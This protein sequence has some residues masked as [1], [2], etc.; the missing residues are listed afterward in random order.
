MKIRNLDDWLAVESALEE[1][2]YLTQD[3]IRHLNSDFNY[4][5]YIQFYE[6]LDEILAEK[7]GTQVDG[8]EEKKVQKPSER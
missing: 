3:E 7:E 2:L 8:A 6:K 4:K 5:H 1:D